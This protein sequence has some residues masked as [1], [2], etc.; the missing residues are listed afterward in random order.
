M[1][2]IYTYSPETNNVPKNTVLQPFCRYCFFYIFVRIL[3]FIVLELD[4]QWSFVS[5]RTACCGFFQQEKS[6]GFGR[7]FMVPI[8][9][10]AVL[11]LMYFYISTFR[12]MCVIIIIIIIIANV[13]T[14]SIAHIVIFKFSTIVGSYKLKLFF[15]H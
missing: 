13:I 10:A 3:C 4:F 12:S 11:I 8:S 2:G 1:Q 9:L 5:Y 14:F 6:D 7:E 15:F